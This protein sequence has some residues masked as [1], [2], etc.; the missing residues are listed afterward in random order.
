MVKFVDIQEREKEILNLIVDSYITESKPISS[1]YLCGKYSLSYSPA[2]VRNIMVS[3]E[4]QGFLSHLH[5]SSG[6]VPTQAGFRSYVERL[7]E[8]TV[9]EI[10]QAVLSSALQEISDLN[11]AV[12]YILNSLSEMS[13]Y[14]SLVAISGRSGRM[15]FRGTRF[16]LEQPEF[17]DIVRLKGLFYALEVKMEQFQEILLSISRRGTLQC[18]P[19]DEGINIIIGDDIGF[20]EI[21]ECSLVVSGVRVTDVFYA[22]ALLGPI[23]MNYSRAAACLTSVTNEFKL[24]VGDL[25]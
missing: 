3:L 4:N 8:E 22:L 12:N 16:I 10:T 19:T 25:L 5:T 14:T 24:V 20:D 21:S 1:S 13:G 15:F 23:R 11:A 17:E 18:D 6:R 9:P 2:T 7:K